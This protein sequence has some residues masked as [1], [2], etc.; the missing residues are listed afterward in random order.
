MYLQENFIKFT[1]GHVRQQDF[2]GTC[3]YSFNPTSDQPLSLLEPTKENLWRKNLRKFKR[4]LAVFNCCVLWAQLIHEI[5]SKSKVTAGTKL[6]NYF[7]SL[8]V[9]TITLQK[10]TTLKHSGNTIEL[11]NLIMRFENNNLMRMEAP[12]ILTKSYKLLIKIC[13]LG[14]RFGTPI[15][16]VGYV[17]ERWMIPC[18][19]ATSGYLLLSECE[20]GFDETGNRW[21]V[22]SKLGL[23]LVVL[24]TLWM[25]LDSFGCWALQLED[26]TFV[27]SICF[28]NYVKVFMIRIN[29]DNDSN[30][31]NY[32]V[33]R[34]LQILNRYYNVI[35]QNVLF[36]ST[37]VLVTNGFIVS[38]YVM[39]SNGSNVTVLQLF[40]FLNGGSNCFLVILIQIGAMAKL[41]GES[42]MVIQNLKKSVTRRDMSGRKRKWIQR[43]LKSLTPLRVAV[44]SVN[45]IDELTPINLLDFCV[46]QIVSLLLL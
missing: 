22:Q 40:Q 21:S 42:S 28:W 17:L 8:T 15:I 20:E 33:Y 46:S 2:I 32:L 10:W 25:N 5:K 9:S 27:Q 14:L 24:T 19:A 31:D 18:N 30:I 11:F 43:Y 45:F 38:T 4:F 26:L 1:R 13:V 7:C 23:L 37:L 36:T 44:G 41:Y 6:A 39:L 35:Q 12:R 29:S 16:V 3:P 34:Q